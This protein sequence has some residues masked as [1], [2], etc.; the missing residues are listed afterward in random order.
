MIINE[1]TILRQTHHPSI[2]SLLEVHEFRGIVYLVLESFQ[3]NSL[4]SIINQKIQLSELQKFKIMEK[5]LKALKYLHS[6]GIIHRG[7]N[8]SNI[9]FRSNQ[10]FDDIVIA[11]FS[12]AAY[13][14]HD[15]QYNFKQCGIPG[16][17]APE[18]LYGWK[19]NYK[20]DVFGAGS[21]FYLL[22]MG[23]P[24]FKGDD[25]QEILT[26]NY[27]FKGILQEDEHK[28][29]KINNVWK[30]LLEKML[31]RFPKERIT[32]MEALEI[33]MFKKQNKE[34]EIYVKYD[35]FESPA[36]IPYEGVSQRHPIK[37]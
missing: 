15:N 25:L 31:Q 30:E 13:Y 37:F 11:D 3:S 24:L 19:Y 34:N 33:E 32:A 29:S 6:E 16:F 10:D 35:Y 23:E 28:F 17:L 36:T 8:P 26:M 9:L 7:I 22:I 20:I 1:I 5:I 2:I 12:L 18:I 21:V 4:N 27:E 14:N